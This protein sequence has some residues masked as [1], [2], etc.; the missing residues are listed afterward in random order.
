MTR[1]IVGDLLIEDNAV[2]FSPG[3]GH[4]VTN[5]QTAILTQTANRLGKI[6]V[7]DRY[8]SDPM[9]A[10]YLETIYSRKEPR[11]EHGVPERS[12]MDSIM[13]QYKEL[14]GDAH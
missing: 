5:A 13:A 14:H 2:R 10:D 4:V 1:V 3:V 7:N 9:F 6:A 11:N 12:I 8:P